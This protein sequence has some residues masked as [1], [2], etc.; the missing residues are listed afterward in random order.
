MTPWDED[1]ARLVFEAVAIFVTIPLL[2]AA[3]FEMLVFHSVG[4]A[5]LC[6]LTEGVA[7][8]LAGA[9]WSA[10]GRLPD[11]ALPCVHRAAVALQ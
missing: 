10:A 5:Y 9:S 3:L 11:V 8:I 6:G 1:H 7:F 2:L 4:L